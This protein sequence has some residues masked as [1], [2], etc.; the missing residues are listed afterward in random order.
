MPIKV[1]YVG[2]LPLKVFRDYTFV[3]DVND[4][5]EHAVELPDNIANDALKHRDVFMQWNL[6]V[7]QHVKDLPF[8]R[9]DALEREGREGIDHWSLRVAAAMMMEDDT[10]AKQAVKE[11]ELAGAKKQVEHFQALVV[12]GITERAALNVSSGTGVPAASLG[13]AEIQGDVMAQVL[14][15]MDALT[16]VLASK[17]A[18]N[19]ALRDQIHAITKQMTDDARER[20]EDPVSAPSVGEFGVDVNLA[21]TGETEPEAP[22]ADF[23][24]IFPEP[25]PAIRRGR[26]A[27]A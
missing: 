8:K 24:A 20:P 4:I 10:K 7:P 17:D 13:Q 11:A 19:A 14:A 5:A 27:K 12:R 1:K 3:R 21:E 9:V 16:A 25:A 26:P 18:E 23:P 2:P 15:R 22:P 6:P